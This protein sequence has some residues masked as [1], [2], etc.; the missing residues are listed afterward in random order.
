MAKPARANPCPGPCL[1]GSDL[2]RGTAG[3]DLVDDGAKPSASAAA[4]RPAEAAGEAS[5]GRGGRRLPTPRPESEPGLGRPSSCERGGTG[6]LGARPC[7][8][9]PEERPP[10]ENSGERGKTCRPW[11]GAESPA[12]EKSGI[13][14]ATPE[15]GVADPPRNRLSGASA[16]KARLGR[17]R[18]ATGTWKARNGLAAAGSS[19][20]AQATAR[21]VGHDW[22]KRS[23]PLAQSSES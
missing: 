20:G 16:D 2:D 7:A 4:R 12:M 22:R 23:Q 15:V 11:P 17:G 18:L 6:S 19:G 3:A 14:E 1:A 13:E 8:E 10:T 5:V 21:Q 9:R